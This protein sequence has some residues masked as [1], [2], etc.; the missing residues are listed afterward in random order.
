MVAKGTKKGSIRF[1]L[2]PGTAVKSVQVAGDFNDWKP[3]TMK[4]QKSGAFQVDLAVKAGSY[5]YKFIVDGQWLS[6]PDND[7]CIPNAYGTM[8]SVVVQA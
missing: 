2:K 8:N 7:N 5:Q 4:K 1:S 6:D 3:A